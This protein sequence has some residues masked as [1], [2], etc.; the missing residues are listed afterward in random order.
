MN[1]RLKFA[2]LIALP[3]SAWALFTWAVA[4][5]PP[6]A[7]DDSWPYY[8][9]DA[10]GMRY[11]SLTQINR[12]NVASLKLAWTFRTGDISESTGRRKR[13]G[14][15]TTPLL[16]DETLYLTTAFN[17]IVAL[18]PGTGQQRW[19]YDPPAPTTSPA[20]AA[21]SNPRKTLGWSPSTPPRVPPAPTSAK[22]ARS[23]SAT[24]F[25]TIPAGIT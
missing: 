3:L 1:R 20:T 5:S 15:E 19:A 25:N 7:P 10:G 17:R 12:D 6:E 21:S 14:F 24:S 13:S 16:V 22:P 2:W 4:P 23:A 8:G 18:D 11:S 9:H